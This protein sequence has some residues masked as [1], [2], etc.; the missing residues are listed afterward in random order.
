MSN[1]LVNE[2]SLQN[3]ASAIREK[4]GTATTYTPSEMASGIS[5]IKYKPLF[6]SFAS[7]VNTYRNKVPI[8]D[9]M[10]K[11]VDTSLIENMG[12]I[13]T[14]ASNKSF[15]LSTWNTSNVRNMESMFGGCSLLQKL[16]ISGFTVISGVTTIKNMFSNCTTLN[17]L[18]MR[19][20]DITVALITSSPFQNVPTTCEI[21]VGNSTIKEWF[22]TNFSSYTNV[23]TATEYDAKCHI[24]LE[25]GNASSISKKYYYS[26]TVGDTTT[27][28]DSTDITTPTGK[29]FDHWEDSEGNTVTSFTATTNNSVEFTA[30]YVDSE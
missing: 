16:D 18:D 11:N 1:V 26:I 30:I 3:I 19:N 2:T 15:D 21:V 27:L 10:V 25:Y 13:F 14:Q 28:P 6:I 20:F 23:M 8:N 29:V 5:S 22:A 4:N 17:L 12:Y 7:N 9:Y 24:H